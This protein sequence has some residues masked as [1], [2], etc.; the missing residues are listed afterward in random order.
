MLLITL[1][2]SLASQ[3]FCTSRSTATVI[4][5]LH[6]NAS[7]ISGLDIPSKTADDAPRKAPSSPRTTAAIADFAEFLDVAASTFIFT[8]PSG[9]G[10]HFGPSTDFAFTATSLAAD[11]D[12]F[13]SAKNLLTKL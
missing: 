4:P 13:K 5:S 8:K 3:N 11:L 10:I 7:K 12:N 6:G 9:G 1:L 2:Q